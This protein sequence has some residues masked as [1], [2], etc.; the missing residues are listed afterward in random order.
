[1]SVRNDFYSQVSMWSKQ[2]QRPCCHSDSAMIAEKSMNNHYDQNISWTSVEF[3]LQLQNF[4]M[5]ALYSQSVVRS[6]N[7]LRKFIWAEMPFGSWHNR[8]QKKNT[9]PPALHSPVKSSQQ[10]FK[11]IEPFQTTWQK[12]NFGVS[13]FSSRISF[14]VNFEVASKLRSAILTPPS[15]RDHKRI[16][17]SLQS[18]VLKTEQMSLAFNET[19]MSQK[20]AIL[21][22][23]LFYH[24]LYCHS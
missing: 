12:L 7:A 8:Q 6:W 20:I 10:R 18:P 14:W 17:T 3:S 19:K 21:L 9:R 5:L 13:I 2:P 15:Y 23:L 16:N 11:L 22:S 1:M 4:R 24:S